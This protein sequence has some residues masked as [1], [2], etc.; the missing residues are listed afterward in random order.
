MS[1]FIDQ[2]TGVPE[3][4]RTLRFIGNN[5][6]VMSLC[7]I[8][9]PLRIPY[10]GFSALDA[11]YVVPGCRAYEGQLVGSDP[12][13]LAILLVHLLDRLV[14]VPRQPV[15]DPRE[16]RNAVEAPT[17]DPAEWVEEDVVDGRV[18]K[19][20]LRCQRQEGIM[21]ISGVD[22]DTEQM[23]AQ[24]RIPLNEDMLE[25]FPAVGDQFCCCCWDRFPFVIQ[26]RETE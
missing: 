2:A 25:S 21:H 13:Y 26:V 15:S 5:D 11:V 19:S 10:K 1:V 8:G 4:T 12:H 3:S 17:G 24:R 22:T 7:Q 6:I 23:A 9:I 18:D 16:S 14:Q 20:L